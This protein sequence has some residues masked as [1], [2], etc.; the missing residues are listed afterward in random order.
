MTE[1]DKGKAS[2]RGCRKE[3][4]GNKYCYGG[5]AF[6]PVTNEQAKVCHYGGFVC[7]FDC[8]YKAHLELES[9]MPGHMGQRSLCVNTVKEMERKWGI[10]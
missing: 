9:S 7:S 3:L 4:R 1:F 5:P 6:D 8:D 2:C 10:N